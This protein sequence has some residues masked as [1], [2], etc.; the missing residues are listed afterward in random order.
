MMGG[1]VKGQ[2]PKPEF[3]VKRAVVLKAAEAKVISPKNVVTGEWV[4]LKCQ[5]GCDGYGGRLTCPP[6]SPTPSQMRKVLDEYAVGVLIHYTEEDWPVVDSI[7]AVLE[8]E[9]FLSGYY[10]ALGLGSGPCDLCEECELEGGC[11]HAE[12]ARPSLE[13][14]GVDV[15][16]TV[17]AAGFPIEV[18]REYSSPQNY[19]GLLLLE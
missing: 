16:A 14:C 12:Q 15:F 3:F 13:A 9:A 1:M 11:R 7:V 19:Y 2:L 8:R 5:Y 4:R 17:L 18:V 10:K 6:Y